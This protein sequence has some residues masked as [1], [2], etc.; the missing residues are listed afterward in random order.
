MTREQ[1]FLAHLP[2]IDRVIA[3]VCARRCLRGA[4]AEDFG[5]IVKTRLIENDYDILAKFEGRSSFKTY[6]A[7]VVNHLYL[8]FQVQRFGKWRPS[9]EA[10]RLGPVARRL[11]CLLYRDGLTFDEACGVLVSDT[12]LRETRDALYEMSVRLPS[13]PVRNRVGEGHDP[14]GHNEGL[15]VVER[16]ERQALADRIFVV[17]RRTLRLL[18]A[19]DHLF[20]RLHMETG[21][22]VAE[23]ARVLGCEQKALYRRK[24]TILR[25][26]RAGLEAHGIGSADALELLATLDWDAAFSIEPSAGVVGHEQSVSRPSTEVKEQARPVEGES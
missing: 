4:D 14:I 7:A 19:R 23:A 22:T 10:R 26:L 8:D 21:L 9:A 18:P 25:Q 17:I 3:W 5:S 2:V 11:E 15:A 12:R 6:L 1:A 24:D 20:L 13:R 16:S